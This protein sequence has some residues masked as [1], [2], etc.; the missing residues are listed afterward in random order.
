MAHYQI[1]ERMGSTSGSHLHRGRQ[2]ADGAPVL[3]KLP[4][5]ADAASHAPRFRRE[6]ALLASL[7]TPA[8]A[9]PLALIDEPA[10]LLMAL[11][12]ADGE[13]LES[14]LVH[15]K[16]DLGRCLRLAVRLAQVLGALHAAH[17]VHHDFRPANLLLLPHDEVRLMDLSLA[18]SDQ[19]PPEPQDRPLVGD[20][21]YVSPE[22]TGRMNR[23]VDYRTD[24]YSFGVMLYRMLTGTLPCHGGD[25]LEW[26]HC[27]LAGVPRPPAELDPAVPLVLSAI[28]LRLLE[29]MPEDRYQSA[30]GLHADLER[31]LAAWNAGG[32][33]PPFP[34][35]EQD[36]L[37]SFQVPHTLLGREAELGQLLERHAA[38]AASGRAELVLVTGAPGVGKTALVCELRQ[39]IMERGGLFACGKFEQFQ[40]DM[41]Y[42]TV[43][44]A[45]REL[46][47]QLLVESEARLARWRGQILQAVGANGQLIV[48]VLPQLELIIGPQ[49]PPPRLAPAEA[50]NRFRMVFQKF[51]GVFA[52]RA[53][54]LTLVLDDL[55]WADAASLAL[56]GDL[57]AP[58]ERHCLLVIG[59]CSDGALE[60]GQPLAP[61]GATVTE[62]ALAPLPE[63]ALC[64]FLARMLHCGP[65][66]AA[67]LARLV[68]RKT[69]GNPFF[70]IQFMSA[71]ADEGLVWFDPGPRSWQWD[72]AR[73]AARDYTDNVA[74]LMI[75]KLARLTPAALAALQA[76]ACIGSAAPAGA[77]F[78]LA[79][80]A[81]DDTAAGLA[82]AVRAGLVSQ[83]Q[84]VVRF[85]HDRVQ[86]AAYLSLDE[87][88][89][90]AL[91]L[92]IARWLYAGRS[93]R[94]LE[95]AVFA[96]VDQFNR[97]AGAITEAAE[98][99]LLCRLNILAGI[100]AKAGA[101]LV[102]ARSFLDRALA[103]MPSDMWEARYPE[104]LELCLALSECE[105][106]AGHFERA[107]ELAALVL[108]HARDR[109]ARARVHLLR[110]AL[111][112]VAGRVD[113]AVASM[114]EGARLFDVAFPDD[115]ADI[116]AAVEAEVGD[117]GAWLRGRSVAEIA[118]ARPLADADIGIALALLVEAIPA[119]YMVRP[120]WFS[121][122]IARAVRLSLRY[123]PNEDSC[124]AYS[125]YGILLI[126]RRRDIASALAFSAM[127]LRLN[128]KLG[129]RR[130]KGRLVATHAIAYSLLQDS[131]AQVRPMLDQAFAASM[132]VG[133]PVYASY[134]TMIYF[135]L[136]LQQG[137]PL[138]EVMHETGAH[139]AFARDNHNEAVL[140]TLRFQQQF[141][142]NM[143]G[144]TRGPSMDSEDFDEAASFAALEK[145][146]FGFGLQSSCIA[147]QVASFIRRDYAGALA[148]AEC[149]AG[150][151]H[152]SGN[153]I[154]FDSVHHFFLG[155]TL[156]ALYP[157]AAGPR[158]REI[159]ARL[160][161]ELDRHGL[162]AASSPDNFS[163]RLALLQA[164]VAR[165]EG[166]AGDAA[167]LYEQ[168]IRAARRNGF[169][170]NEAI[171]FELAAGYYR[172]HGFDLIAD[173][174]LGEARAA[175]VR[176]GADAKV[177]QLDAGYPQL[178]AAAPAPAGDALQLDLLSVVK[179]SQ[180][181]SSQI[182]LDELVDT[183]MRIVLENAGAQAGYL[184]LVRGEELVLA[185]E[186]A[187][188]RHAVQVRRDREAA[189][190]PSS[191]LNYARRSLEPVLLHDA[192]QPN[193][194][195]GD[196]YFAS[197]QPKSVLCLPIL[198]QEALAGMLYLENKLVT[199]AFAPIRVAALQLLASQAAISLENARL[200]AES[201]EREAKI[202]RLFE[203]N[204][205]GIFY[206]SLDGHIV[207][208]NDAGLALIQYSREELRE[209]NIRWRE[210]TPPEWRAA[211]ERA[212][213]EIQAT[214]A[215]RP[216]EKEY[217]LKDGSRLPVLVTAARF[218]GASDQGVAFV[219]DLS[220]RKRVE[221]Q[222][223]HM[224]NHDVLTGLPN[225]T[226]LH[227][228]LSQAISVAHRNGGKLGLLFI[229]L[230]LFKYI[231]ESLGHQVG[232]VVLK[233]AG[234]RLQGCLREGDSVARLGGDEFVIVLPVLADGSDAA[235]VA[236][237]A[238]E[239]LAQP[240]QVDAHEL[241]ASGSIGISLYPDDGLDAAAL[242]RAADTA[243][244]HA[245]ETGRGK[246]Q[247]F[248]AAMNRAAQQRMEVGTR[249]RQALV[250]DEFVLHYQPQVDMDSGSIMAAEAL[251]RWQRPGGQP[252]SCGT[253]IGNAEESGL[254]V[255]IGE[256]TLRQACRQ[257]RAWRDAGHPQLKIAVNLSP[258]QLEPP[259]FC[260]LVGD[261]L[262]ES[263]LPADALELEITE[264]IFLQRSEINLSTLT[265][266]RDMGVIL[267]VDDF[268][269][270][271]SS[272]AYL[273]RFP[274]HAL[275][276]DQSFIR[277]IGTDRN[278]TA[279]ITAIIAM[280][281]SL[282]LGVMA[283]G[284]ETREQASFLLAHGCHFA[285]GFYYSR[286]VPAQVFAE[287][288]RG[289]LTI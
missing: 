30:Q 238:L 109:C 251:L 89:R 278:H 16:L 50:R 159:A 179:A 200:F 202:R 259:D 22:K 46:V 240:F 194:F 90:Q 150:Y 163:D 245:K 33:V 96:I 216:F 79:G 21:A 51:I 210:M 41:P 284:V 162:W 165:I 151:A 68:H 186:A 12:P 236:H 173:T 169:V 9:R 72:L 167:R 123:G 249:L 142:A 283:E 140:H 94:Q 87:A 146:S 127:A 178:Q 17:V 103:L 280:A 188:E 18:A 117:I 207:D 143:K 107:E 11:A 274:V 135:W 239:L 175:Y 98:S 4:L 60:D 185:A 209:G 1:L 105:Y 253:F 234:E 62:L 55:Q 227:D 204:I 237:K 268:G 137:V 224:A 158:Q 211:D 196:P 261:I 86:E 256:W 40:R 183:L 276:I 99:D 230:D 36:V 2:V 125:C 14:V 115:A 252:V 119:A 277:D 92:R 65:D 145:A 133:D 254:I 257:L 53:H 154:I 26:A 218:E 282:Q 110:I 144:Q 248:T 156:A 192:A 271:Y 67:P 78:E 25:P 126:A 177:A 264:S 265:T 270:G 138:G 59:A 71:L 66:A 120:A 136:A 153:M 228:R 64:D 171:A 3:L 148:A 23:S 31:C 132:D 190:L 275:K 232:D 45:F 32:A 262:D 208:A 243:M 285:Q 20:W 172:A 112:Q 58:R 197:H 116:D 113:E 28:V 15:G 231:N 201:A 19:L 215:C 263:G 203:S 217:V 38:V 266:L 199:H 244:Y 287:L 35:G 106:L 83:V 272:L 7:D 223:R 288:L 114:V 267:S 147:R 273:Q 129:G 10:K 118:D 76:L 250:H 221:E 139:A 95:D 212:L 48:D 8:V 81:A 168:A 235:L 70:V 255:P 174:Y 222:V 101:A 37:A 108:A 166:R 93:A 206:Y 44:Q 49:P 233:M 75:A 160:S 34:L 97:G 56:L 155:L 198:R 279:L 241:H 182:V 164:E 91:H 57:L 213:A 42:D 122:I 5:S 184:L 111:Y 77:L 269:T 63:T 130:R 27:H 242:M 88:A 247:F 52:Q 13:L 286:A 205:V 180:A 187:L 74:G 161:A 61:V 84:G 258:R 100:K 104:S 73:I 157:Q 80:P 54:P 226:L 181:V 39:P 220:E 69:G 189:P 149:A 246:F 214:G 47:R 121:L 124:F 82:A 176:W 152:E 6:F 29:K 193:P 229:D 134:I 170:Q 281:K 43:T 219:L 289:R 195:S 260:A 128:D 85:L 191:I 131:M 102:S 225:R 24:F 141:V